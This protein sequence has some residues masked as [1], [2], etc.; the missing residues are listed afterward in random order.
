VRAILRRACY[1]CHSN[2]TFWPWYSRIAPISWLVARDVHEGRKELNFSTW[3]RYTTKQQLKNFKESWAE[4]AEGE[5][6]PWIYLPVHRDAVLSAEDRR[7]LRTW[8]LGAAQAPGP[9][10]EK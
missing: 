10:G 8:A 1:D 6:P 7:L 5:M 9:S 3:N 2:E 4:V